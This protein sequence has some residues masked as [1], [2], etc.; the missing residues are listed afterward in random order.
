[1]HKFIEEKHRATTQSIW[2]YYEANVPISHS[3]YSTKAKNPAR[4]HFIFRLLSTQHTHSI[5][6][7]I[8]VRVSP[9]KKGVFVLNMNIYAF[10]AR[11]FIYKLIR[12]GDIFYFWRKWKEFLFRKS[13]KHAAAIH[14]YWWIDDGNV[15]MADGSKEY[16]SEDENATIGAHKVHNVIMW[17]INQPTSG[18]IIIYSDETEERC[19]SVDCHYF[20][21]LL[22]YRF[23]S[24]HWPHSTEASTITKWIFFLLLQFEFGKYWSVW[25]PSI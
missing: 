16:I 18:Q 1:M 15:N 13:I 8:L 14:A 4:V 7:S 23:H 25:L 17:S 2:I 21:F 11:I 20:L 5:C 24:G 9:N 10:A 12:F 6:L 3:S 22:H 19:H